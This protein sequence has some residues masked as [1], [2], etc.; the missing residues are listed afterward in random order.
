[1]AYNL[2]NINKC[3]SKFVIASICV[4]AAILMF[5]ITDFV[6]ISGAVAQTNAS[7][8]ETKRIIEMYSGGSC[9]NLIDSS[10]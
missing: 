5:I 3:P 10:P 2:I 1:M 7:N 4:M 9:N 6:Y 8:I